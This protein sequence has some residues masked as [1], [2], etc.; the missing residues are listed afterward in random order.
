MFSCTDPLTSWSTAVIGSKKFIRHWQSDMV[1][2]ENHKKSK[3]M[4]IFSTFVAL[5]VMFITYIYGSSRNLNLGHLLCLIY[6]IN[7]FMTVE[8]LLLKVVTDH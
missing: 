6:W 7:F 1:S 5:Q 2:F 4:M 8:P 3:I